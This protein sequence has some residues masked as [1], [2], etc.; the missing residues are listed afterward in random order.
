[1]EN[2][3]DSSALIETDFAHD[4]QLFAKRSRFIFLRLIA[5][6]VIPFIYRVLYSSLLLIFILTFSFLFVFIS[7]SNS[8]EVKLIQP[9]FSIG[10]QPGSFPGYNISISEDTKSIYDKSGRSVINVT[11]SLKSFQFHLGYLQKS[12]KFN[13]E[14]YNHITAVGNG[15]N[16]RLGYRYLQFGHVFIQSFLDLDFENINYDNSIE[17]AKGRYQ[18]INYGVSTDI[19]FGFN[20]HD[21]CESSNRYINL[22]MYIQVR[23]GTS[24]PYAFL[25]NNDVRNNH[26]QIGLGFH[27]SFGKW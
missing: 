7:I 19:G 27:G 25:N 17:A 2:N 10:F 6:S 1:M 9:D 4:K 16:T 20:N 12:Y 5:F 24:N 14:N 21:K 11:S 13:S 3:K 18:S 8:Q 23:Y 22:G 15:V 26:I